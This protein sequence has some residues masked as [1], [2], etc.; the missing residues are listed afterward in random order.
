MHSIDYPGFLIGQDDIPQRQ[1][2]GQR[3]EG[4]DHQFDQGESPGSDR[5]SHEDHPRLLARIVVETTARDTGFPSM[6]AFQLTVTTS[7]VA[8]LS[9]VL[10]VTLCETW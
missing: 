8:W 7:V 10:T 6:M 1:D 5:F 3:Q 4:R 2:D 9:G